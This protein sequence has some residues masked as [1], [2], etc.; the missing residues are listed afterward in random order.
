MLFRSRAMSE[1]GTSEWTDGFVELVEAMRAVQ[2]KYFRKRLPDDLER[3][4]A[5]EQE[6]N[7]RIVEYR[8]FLDGRGQ[9]VL[10]EA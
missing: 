9:A 8:R 10:F 4:K 6:V 1:P 2:K 3:A 5:L 7:R